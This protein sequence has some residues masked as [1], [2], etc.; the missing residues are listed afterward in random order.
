MKFFYWLT[1]LNENIYLNSK[2]DY[3]VVHEIFEGK[4]NRWQL[5]NKSNFISFM[6]N[7]CKESGI[8]NEGNE[9]QNET[10]IRNLL[11]IANHFLKFDV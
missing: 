8:R 1:S 7:I 11:S 2:L 9:W 10:K 5:S 4:N 3:D 6:K